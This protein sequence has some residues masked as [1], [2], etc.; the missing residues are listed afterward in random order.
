MLSDLGDQQTT[1]ANLDACNAA[2]AQAQAA[3]ASALSARQAAGEHLKVSTL[4][5][6]ALIE[7]D[8]GVMVDTPIA[9]AAP[10][11]SA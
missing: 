10:T 9:P 11:A 1:Q 6:V 2:L 7:R 3:T 5:Y 8:T 4:A